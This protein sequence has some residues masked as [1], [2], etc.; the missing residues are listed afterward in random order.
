MYRS[1]SVPLRLTL[2]VKLT[3]IDADYR[4]PLSERVE[5]AM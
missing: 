5:H 1:T 4:S 2:N 3:P